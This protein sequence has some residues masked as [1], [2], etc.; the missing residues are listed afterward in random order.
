[1][2]KLNCILKIS[3]ISTAL[4]L[5]GCSSNSSAPTQP[6]EPVNSVTAVNPT[7]VYSKSRTLDNFND[8]VNFLK[9][10]AA[11]EGVS[12]DVL[13]AQNNINYIQKSV[14]LDDQ[15]AGRIRKRDPN[16][17]PIIN[18][19]GTTNYLN[20]VL[21]KNK[22]DTA[23][24]RYW[25]QLPQLENASKKFS[26]PKNYLLALWG[27]ESSFGYYQGNYDVLSTLAT[28]AFDGRRES[29]FSK[30]FIAAMKILQRDHIQRYKMLGSWAGAM[31]QTQFMPS[32]YLSY[33]ADGNN[34]GAKNIWTDHYDVFA[35]IANYLHTVG[36]NENLPWG[37]E[38]V[39][40]QPLDM[41]LAGTEENK[42]RSLSDW[43]NMGVTLKYQ[44]P[45]TQQK[46]TALSGTQDL[47]L[48]RPDRELG[49]AF[50]V[51]NN[52]RTLLHWNKSNYFAVSIGM[53][54]DRIQ[55][56]VGN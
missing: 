38:V 9:G 45:Q 42:K 35:S 28:L 46:L 33:A 34:D 13:N 2:M 19:N 40:T 4:F 6:S 8:Y 55:Q 5:A 51:S 53:F 27:M 24:A 37:V 25:E 22:V 39:L 20:R 16:A 21:T 44:T 54:A 15:Q 52:Y 50:L 29:L 47:W 17:P 43:Q 30:E 31:G 12:A 41:A 1:M 26:V 23:E 7:A 32:S 48:V 11:A 3:G 49:R 14:D 10:K 56:R 18:P 36:W